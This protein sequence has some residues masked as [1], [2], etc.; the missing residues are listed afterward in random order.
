[1]VKALTTVNSLETK[2]IM[3][4]YDSDYIF[5]T[6]SD[7]EK[8]YVF[9]KLAGYDDLEYLVNYEPTDKALDAVFFKMIN[10]E[11][12]DGFDL[13]YFDEHVKIYRLIE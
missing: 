7:K 1:V 10:G 4:K 9:F 11:E 13:V 8:N 6:E 3:E 12:I 2:K 5:V